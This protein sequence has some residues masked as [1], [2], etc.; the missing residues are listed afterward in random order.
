MKN[1][2]QCIVQN[3]DVSKHYKNKEGLNSTYK[4]IYES[5]LDKQNQLEIFEQLLGDSDYIYFSKSFFEEQRVLLMDIINYA[6]NKGKK[7]LYPEEIESNSDFEELIPLELRGDWSFSRKCNVENYHLCKINTPILFVCGLCEGVGKYKLQMKIRDKFLDNGVNTVLIGSRRESELLG[8]YCIPD[9]MFQV[10]V[11]EKD[12]IVAFNHYV[13]RIELEESPDI[14]LIGIP[15]SIGNFTRSVLEN[16]GVTLWEI[17][18]AVYP[19]YMICSIPLGIA[20]T[21][22]LKQR[23][24]R[25]TGITCNYLHLENK[26]ID[27]MTVKRDEKIRL[28]DV[29]NNDVD[30]LLKSSPK[31]WECNLNNEI[32]LNKLVDEIL[33]HF[34]SESEIEMV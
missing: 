32:E 13:K 28:L 10:G 31:E 3:E 16:M 26:M 17:S 34:K 11:T 21:E 2:V 25:S 24:E 15:G 6:K 30:N 8:E 33:V 14:I 12:K 18:Q 19:D 29:N 23:I 20:N 9:Y 1:V 5:M 7:I 4:I 22:L 27:L